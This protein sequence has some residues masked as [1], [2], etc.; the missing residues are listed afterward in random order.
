MNRKSNRS[1]FKYERT[2]L[3]SSLFVRVIQK[4][5]IK[6]KLM[7]TEK[8]KP[9]F[10]QTADTSWIHIFAVQIFLF[11]HFPFCEHFNLS[12]ASPSIARP[13]W[14]THAVTHSRRSVTSTMCAPF[15]SLS[16]CLPNDSICWYLHLKIFEKKLISFFVDEKELNGRAKVKSIIDRRRRK[17]KIL[18]SITFCG[19]ILQQCCAAT[20]NST[21]KI[22]ESFL[23]KKRS[24]S[25]DAL[26][27]FHARHVYAVGITIICIPDRRRRRRRRHAKQ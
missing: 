24:P 8:P 23:M 4:H 11:I 9:A 6:C 1:G 5:V 7:W 25:D 27:W 20:R 14:T 10:R 21:R 15:Q 19:S 17:N 3:F 22:I 13:H 18:L 16:Q 26:L 2:L 12:T